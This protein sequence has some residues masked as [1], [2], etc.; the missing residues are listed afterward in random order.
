VVLRGLV[1]RGVGAHLDQPAQLPAANGNSRIL[2]IA[3]AS[4]RA[5]ASS[6]W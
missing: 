1:S 2:G 5:G 4:A 3:V 6:R